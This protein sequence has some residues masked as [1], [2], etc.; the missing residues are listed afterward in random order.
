MLW[1]LGVVGVLNIGLGLLV[2]QLRFPSWQQVRQLT[3]GGVLR[4][5]F[6]AMLFALGLGAFVIIAVIVAVQSALFS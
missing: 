3:L 4:G 5:C 2:L 1:I 6:A